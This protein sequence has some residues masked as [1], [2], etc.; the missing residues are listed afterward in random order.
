MTTLSNKAWQ[1]PVCDYVIADV[2]YMH[3]KIDPDCPGCNTRKFSAFQCIEW[4][5]VDTPT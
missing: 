4:P 3:I 5:V 1:C 2:M